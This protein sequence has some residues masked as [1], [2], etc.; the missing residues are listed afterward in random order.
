MS[1]ST[2]GVDAKLEDQVKGMMGLI[3]QLGLSDSFM[4]DVAADDIAGTG[5][6]ADG[7][8]NSAEAQS[9]R[10]KGQPVAHI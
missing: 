8:A 4:I 7:A 1:Q 5:L 3:G 6:Q 9:R 10:R 2:Q